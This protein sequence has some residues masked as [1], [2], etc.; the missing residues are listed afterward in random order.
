M[1]ASCY[2]SDKIYDVICMAGIMEFV[3]CG[4]YSDKRLRKIRYWM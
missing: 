1:L 3:T 4:V 2:K